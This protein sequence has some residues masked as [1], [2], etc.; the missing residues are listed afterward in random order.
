[1]GP[2][3]RLRRRWLSLGIDIRFLIFMSVVVF[4]GDALA[5]GEGM[6]NGKSPTAS[7]ICTVLLA[8][9]LIYVWWRM[10]YELRGPGFTRSSRSAS[11]H[12]DAAPTGSSDGQRP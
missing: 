3:G 8:G 9:M 6:R 2:V 7:I 10:Y 5:W 12:S 1:M 11:T 4:A